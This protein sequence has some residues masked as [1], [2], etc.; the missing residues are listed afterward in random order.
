VG[1]HSLSLWQVGRRSAADPTT[2]HWLRRQ[3]SL[4][5]LPLSLAELK[6]QAPSARPGLSV[7]GE[8]TLRIL[9]LLRDGRSL[10]EVAEAIC[11]DP[12]LALPSPDAAL[13]LV[14]R[15]V[16]RTRSPD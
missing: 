7:G 1:D 14:R 12:A 8:R 6:S 9:S 4:E 15:V 13:V 2:V 5:G 11:A 16:S 3:N 10:S